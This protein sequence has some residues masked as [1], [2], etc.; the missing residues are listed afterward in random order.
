MIAV[1]NEI[2]NHPDLFNELLMNEVRAT[3][4]QAEGKLGVDLRLYT[5][6]ITTISKLRAA[7]AQ[8]KHD[9]TDDEMGSVFGEQ[10]M[11]MNT[12]T[13]LGTYSGHSIMEFI[14]GNPEKVAFLR[15]MHPIVE[16]DLAVTWYARLKIQKDNRVSLGTV[17]H[18]RED[19]PSL[20]KQLHNSG[21]L[22]PIEGE[23]LS[24]IPKC[25]RCVEFLESGD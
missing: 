18:A 5:Q 16:P 13:D 17:L 15:R 24:L 4:A 14:R 11:F 23:I 9:M 21:K 6:D 8:L 3:V 12:H 7:E 20:S 25:T 10:N 1:L 2:L 19:C 22:V